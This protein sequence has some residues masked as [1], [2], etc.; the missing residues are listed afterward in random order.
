MPKLILMVGIPGSGKSFLANQLSREQKGIIVSAD[1][2]FTFNIPACTYFTVG[3]HGKD[4]ER[5]EMQEKYWFER[6]QLNNAHWYCKN[7]VE[8]LMMRN[9]P[10]IIV[11]N[12]NLTWREILPYVDFSIDYQ[13]DIELQEP[14]TWWVNQPEECFQ[15]NSHGVPMIQLE[16]MLA[17]KEPIEDLREQIVRHIADGAGR[18]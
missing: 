5:I 9:Y 17:R 4:Y 14:Q 15:R 10:L 16:R 7:R 8:Y 11:D 18:L 1:Q 6:T 2:W 12:T 3:E 13:Y